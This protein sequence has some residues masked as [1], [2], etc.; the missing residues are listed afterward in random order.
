MSLAHFTSRVPRLT[1]LLVLQAAAIAEEGYDV[2]KAA[3]EDAI[4]VL[5]NA[6]A[7]VGE[8]E[9]AFANA[10]AEVGWTTLGCDAG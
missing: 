3:L 7:L 5:S 2:A 10:A 9:T 4:S 6:D 1:R 8:A